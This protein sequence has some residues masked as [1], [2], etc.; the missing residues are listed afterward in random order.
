MLIEKLTEEKAIVKKLIVVQHASTSVTRLPNVS[1]E[2]LVPELDTI[3]PHAIPNLATV[4]MALVAKMW[5]VSFLHIYANL[6]LDR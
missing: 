6:F 5:G 2:H 3:V 1:L 4:V